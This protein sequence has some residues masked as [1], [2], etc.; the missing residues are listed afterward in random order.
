LI[1]LKGAEDMQGYEELVV[2][3]QNLFKKFLINFYGIWEHPEE[4]Q[5]ISIGVDNGYLMVTF[6]GNSCLHITRPDQWY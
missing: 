3:S 4:H 6:E 1:T 5:P 2:A